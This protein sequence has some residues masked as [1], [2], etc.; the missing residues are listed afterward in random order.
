MHGLNAGTLQLQGGQRC[1]EVQ[2]GSLTS[3]LCS[4]PATLLLAQ[5]Y[6]RVTVGRKAWGR[7]L[8]VSWT[9]RCTN[10]RDARSAAPV[11]LP[12]QVRTALVRARLRCYV[13]SR[14]IVRRVGYSTKVRLI[15]TETLA[16][17]EKHA[18]PRWAPAKFALRSLCQAFA[19][20]TVACSLCAQI[21]YAERMK[22]LQN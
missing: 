21:G 8:Q 5:R 2:R 9:R 15:M 22:H 10:T 12:R 3:G 1:P 19:L 17:R 4:L 16:D 11:L 6:D 14:L 7:P 13:V 18:R 20:S